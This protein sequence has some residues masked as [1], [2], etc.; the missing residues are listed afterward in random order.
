MQDLPFDG[1]IRREFAKKARHRDDLSRV[2]PV[3]PM[4]HAAPDLWHG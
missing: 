2:G 4:I 3:E 1:A